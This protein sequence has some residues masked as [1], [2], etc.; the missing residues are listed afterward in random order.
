MRSLRRAKCTDMPRIVHH[1]SSDRPK[2]RGVR[3]R[4]LRP[5]GS[6]MSVPGCDSVT[7]EAAC[8]MLYSA[9]VSCLTWSGFAALPPSRVTASARRHAG[10]ARTRRPVAAARR[11]RRQACSRPLAIRASVRAI[12]WFRGCAQCRC[13][14]SGRAHRAVRWT[15]GDR[16]VLARFW[17]EIG[18]LR[19]H[20]CLEIR[21]STRK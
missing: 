7:H 2:V 11:Q 19:G 20:A 21:L 9:G 17:P 3:S 8:P 14:G 5:A 18:K 10:P 4:P 15:V 1:R 13:P 16:R 12:P 6:R